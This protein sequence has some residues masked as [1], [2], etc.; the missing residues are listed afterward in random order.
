MVLLPGFE[1]RLC[2]W[3]HPDTHEVHWPS[4]ESPPTKAVRGTAAPRYGRA[5]S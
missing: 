3:R 4:G 2:E 5:S 1:Y